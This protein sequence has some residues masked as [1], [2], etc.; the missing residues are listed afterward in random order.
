MIPLN[1]SVHLDAVSVKEGRWG[2]GTFSKQACWVG[3]P[4]L[5]MTNAQTVLIPLTSRASNL[6]HIIFWLASS[7]PW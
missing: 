7:V 2:F 6:L 3:Y 4:R 1:F 5:L